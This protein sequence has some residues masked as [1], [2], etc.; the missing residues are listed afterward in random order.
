MKIMLIGDVYG[1]S[2]RDVLAAHLPALRK[3]HAVD[4]VIVN[5]DNA[6]HGRGVLPETVKEIYAMGADLLTGGDHIWD[7][8]EIIP[9]LD[10]APFV[11]RPLNYP[12]NTIGKG[13]HVLEL[14]TRKILVIHALGR[15][16][17]DKQ[18]ENP[19]VAI[20]TL[21]QKFVLKKDVDAIVVDFHGNATS[22]KNAMGFFLD[23][24]V[25]AML[26]TNTHVPTADAR[27]LPK[28]TAYMTDVGMTGDYTSMIGA[29]IEAPLQKFVTGIQSG[30]LKPASGPGTLR[31]VIV[32][33]DD[34]TGLA[35]AIQ[36][37]SAGKV[38]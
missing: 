26:G 27:L 18:T 35:T 2:G 19:F 10:R 15:I 29:E 25:S 14:G 34:T 21:L 3:E 31:G 33:I 4:A 38:W 11:L 24:R 20:D 17:M 9:H 32:T 1:R 6:S 16:F 23:G 36:P 30:P 12:P 8:K 37:I 7:Q 28:G 5:V 22:E 13:W